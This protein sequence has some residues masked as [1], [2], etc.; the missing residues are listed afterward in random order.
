MTKFI[1][2]GI[3]FLAAFLRLFYLNEAPPHLNWDEVSHGYN[4]YSILKTG[5]DEWGEAF[6]LTSFR[7]FGDYKLPLYIYFTIPLVFF[8]GLSEWA[9]RLPS[10]LAGIGAVIVTFF[11]VQKLFNNYWLS[12][13]SSFLLSISPWHLM[14]SRAAFEANLALFLVIL[15]AFLFLRGFEDQKFFPLSFLSFGLSLYAYNSAKIFVTLLLLFLFIFYRQELTKKIRIFLPSLFI[16]VLL[17]VPH[18]GLLRSEEGQA[19]FYWTSILD[20]AAIG[21]IG[22]A[23]V[24]SAL[25]DPL[26]RLIHNRPVFFTTSAISN[27]LSHFSPNF[28]FFQGGSHYQYSIPGRGVAYPIEAPFILVGI[29]S[30]FLARQGRLWLILIWFLL[31]PVA[32]SITKESPQVLR[33]I[34]VLP[35]LQILGALGLIKGGEWFGRASRAFIFGV[36]LIFLVFSSLFL[37]EYFSSYRREYS[38]SWQYG[39]EEAIN[40][41]SQNYDKY[42]TIIFTKKYGEPH[43][44]LLFYT[45]WPPEKYRNDK[46]LVR[47]MR[48]N[49][50]WVDRFDKFYFVNDWEIK[51]KVPKLATGKTL[52][53]TSPKN[54]PED[55]EKIEEIKF[56]SGD[57]AFEIYQR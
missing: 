29:I 14:I 3:I 18:L 53:I 13:I 24:T 9:V 34:F 21:R 31:G 10:A 40:F 27:W 48:S 2:A 51:E 30:I 57:P 23:R 6:P 22:E 19:R 43:E 55:S 4:A 11:L 20:Q 36:I 50:Y 39:Y 12:F 54:A 47:Y 1:F 17:L 45:S 56:L 37:F 44:F 5:K 38:W 33:S 52:L 25:P 15:G 8:F 41:V 49:W 42:D 26:P 32:A 16:F 46:N 7:A 35:S 28:L